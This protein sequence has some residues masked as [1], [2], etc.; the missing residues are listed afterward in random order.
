MMVEVLLIC[1]VEILILVANLSLQVYRS[2]LQ[3]VQLLILNLL[4]CYK[5]I[6]M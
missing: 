3:H 2:D 5:L 6:C 1:L 4:R